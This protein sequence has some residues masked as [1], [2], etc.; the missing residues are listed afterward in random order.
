MG[1]CPLKDVTQHVRLNRF[2]V[3][4]FSEKQNE[5]DGQTFDTKIAKR[6]RNRL[7][8]K[9]SLNRDSYTAYCPIGSP[10]FGSISAY[11]SMRFGFLEQPEEMKV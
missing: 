8:N 3:C 1:I 9:D 10:N 6:T 5:F 7:E 2:E 11:F 4:N